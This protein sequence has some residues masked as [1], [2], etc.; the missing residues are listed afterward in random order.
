VIPHPARDSVVD[1]AHELMRTGVL[2]ATE[3]QQQ[4]VRYVREPGVV[5]SR[6]IE[7]N[8][9]ICRPHSPALGRFMKLWWSEINRFTH[10]DQ[11]SVNFAL[12]RSGIVATEILPPGWSARDHPDFALFDHACLERG[13]PQDRADPLPEAAMAE[14]T[15]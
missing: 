15:M 11:L 2:G 6:L 14:E 13:V 1:E 4:L 5:N 8:F 12:C 3:A 10:R 9:Y 7:T